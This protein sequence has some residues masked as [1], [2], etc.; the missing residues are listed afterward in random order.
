[1]SMLIFFSFIVGVIMK[2]WKDVSRRTYLLLIGAL[3]ILCT[4]FLIMT[5]GTVKGQEEMGEVNVSTGH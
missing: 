1:M 2:E 4:S 3:V 5:Y